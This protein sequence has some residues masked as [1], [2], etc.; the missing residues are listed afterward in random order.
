VKPYK[1]KLIKL[2]AS[3]LYTGYVPQAPGTA[4]SLLGI[5]LYILTKRHENFFLI[6]TLVL[7]AIGFLACEKAEEIFGEKDSQKI[8]IDE[9][10]SMCLVCLFTQHDWI[11][12]IA[13]FI[14]FRFFDIVKPYPAKQAEKLKGSKA[15]MLDDMVAAL[16]AIC[17]L[18][19]LRL[20]GILPVW[21]I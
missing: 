17:V 7:F 5:A 21:N 1:A 15:V 4:G 20:S 18:F 12:L 10:A 6:I 3:G 13:G 14:F 16:Y 11:M 19:A 2:I 8:V 9:T